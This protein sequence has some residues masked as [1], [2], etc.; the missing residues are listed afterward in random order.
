M[1]D[2]TATADRI[3]DDADAP[4]RLPSAALQ[5]CR[6]AEARLK[7]TSRAVDKGIT[8]LGAKGVDDLAEKLGY[9]RLAFYRLRVGQ[10]RISL[11]EA[12]ALA[13]RIG[14]SFVDTF[15]RV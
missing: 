4:L 1:P 14:L 3:R 10:G 11:D 2:A 12:A 9:K 8:R 15:E 6:D 13:K 7:I 5:L